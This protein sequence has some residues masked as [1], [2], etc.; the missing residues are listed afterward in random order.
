MKRLQDRHL[1]P[2]F[3]LTSLLVFAAV[4]V[5]LWWALGAI[6]REQTEITSQEHAE[7][8]TYSVIGP[9]LS[10]IDL[11]RPIR[12]G[13]PRYDELRD[14]VVSD[15][16]RVQF[17]VVTVRVWSPDGTI[18]FADDPGLVGRRFDRTP[19]LRSAFGGQVVSVPSDPDHR[20]NLS[21]RGLR[22]ILAT[23]V[24]LAAGDLAQDP[25][26]VVEID[27]DVAAA[28]VPVGRPFRVV[29]LALVGGLTAIYVVQLPLV[30]RLGRTLREQNR[31]LGALLRQEQETVEELR[32]LNRRQ[33]EFLAVTSHELRT[34]LTSIAGY[35]KT[36]LQPA[37]ADD[38]ATREEFLHAIDRQAAR[39]NTLIENILA[40]TRSS[41]SALDAGS[42]SLAEVVSSILDRLGQD[43]GR[44]D[45]DIPGGLPDVR[46]DRRLMEL[47]MGN[48]VDNALKFSPDGSRCR[49]GASR[50]PGELVV[51]VEDDGV[52]IPSEHMTRVFDRF[53]QIDASSTRRH[54]GVGLGLH[55]VKTIVEGAGG[56][57]GVESEPGSG[58]RF[59]LRLP[60]TDP[61]AKERQLVPEQAR[62]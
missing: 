38:P 8:V 19:G 14:L 51:W 12:P 1:V 41:G 49:V 33:G 9:A 55:L 57:I 28:A 15:V 3:A 60:V 48:L 20:V 46:V 5:T 17:P 53:Y 44:V 18:L 54:G 43:A 32:T 42:A 27:T 29:G 4:A 2:R 39:L 34:P 24:P 30:R 26:A 59:S 10:G 7:F 47:V 61:E 6:I 16:I 22:S 37:F 13:G 40:V 45:V 11:D 56:T 31:R 36:L 21:E 35:T 50:S 62:T 25:P 23:F 52:G 58:S